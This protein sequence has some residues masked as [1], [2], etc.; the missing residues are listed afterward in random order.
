M[1]MMAEKGVE[2][3]L[4]PSYPSKTFPNHY[5]LVT[6]LYP[7]HHGIVANNFYDVKTGESFSLGNAEQKTNPVYYGGDPIL[8]SDKDLRLLFSIG[9]VLMYV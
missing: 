8:L 1:D 6:G 4:I 3:G 9:Q 5:T 2:S 7:D